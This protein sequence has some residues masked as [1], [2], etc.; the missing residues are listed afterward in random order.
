M[1]TGPTVIMNGL[2]RTATP[3]WPP[4]VVKCICRAH[5]GTTQGA[6][7]REIFDRFVGT[8]FHAD[9]DAARAT[10][11]NLVTKA[12]LARTDRQRRADALVAIFTAAVSTAPGA[13]APEPV[14][15]IVIDH[16]TFETH[17]AHLAGGPAPVSDP[18]DVD[19]YRCETTTGIPI[20]PTDAVIAALIGHIRRVVIDSTGTVIDLGRR[21]RLFTGAARTAIELINRRCGWGACDIRDTQI[22]HTTPWADGGTTSPDNGGPACGR[23][24]RIKTRGYT[25]HRHPDGHWSTHRPDGTPITQPR[26]P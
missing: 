20:D 19:R 4:S 17:L 12:L 23:H 8:E 16:K 26:A 5:V 15:N 22:D 18:T 21:R 1:P 2:M 7:L 25:T 24:N 9:W 6:V 13:T 11:G 10:H 14:V 3:S